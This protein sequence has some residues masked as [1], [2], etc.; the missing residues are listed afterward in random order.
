[1]T[2]LKFKPSPDFERLKKVLL[3]EGEPDRVPLVELIVNQP[4]KEAFLDKPIKSIQDDITF[5]YR[6]GYDYI[7][8]CPAYDFKLFANPKEGV[9]KTLFKRSSYTQEDVDVQWAPE[10][11]GCITTL[12]DFE[13]HPWP[14]IEDV[15]FSNIKEASKI[16]PE[17]MKIIARA[18]DIFTHTWEALGFTNFSYALFENT[19]L[20]EKVFDKI[21]TLIYKIFEIEAKFDNIGALWY[22]DDIAYT[23]GLMTSPDVLR[24]HLFPWMKKIGELAK[25]YNLP[26][27]YH[28]DGKLWQVMDD[29][30]E[31]GINAL[32][33]IETK[34]MD[35]REVKSKYG[36]M[37]CLIG[38]IEVD[39]L[40]RGTPEEIDNLVRDRIKNIGQGGGY[41]VGSSNTVP[42][43][44]PLKNYIAMLEA[45]FKYGKYPIII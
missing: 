24:R 11:E 5:W 22:S 42:E 34:A 10:G 29:L 43:Y 20:V 26:Y 9:R 38:N 33:P 25:R 8:L 28:T 44:V 36:N 45:T 6:A 23:E 18:G 14:S 13:N 4:V 7:S 27:L 32:Q 19:R 2:G 16:L 40:A 39:R 15:D 41:C 12:Q 35:I 30:I 21:G 1:M 3:L 31:C 37:L 17:G